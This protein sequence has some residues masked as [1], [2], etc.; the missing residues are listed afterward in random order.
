MSRTIRAGQTIFLNPGD[1]RVITFDW[2]AKALPAAVTI[3]SSIWTIDSVKQ[4][5]DTALTS[6]NDD[7]GA[8]SRTTLV[9]L[10]ATTASDGDLYTLTNTIVTNESPAQ[11]IARSCP[12]FVTSQTED[13]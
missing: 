13:K 5:G 8:D 7:I 10:L 1:Q 12:V 11:T 3:S 2:D 4:N 6:D 9:R